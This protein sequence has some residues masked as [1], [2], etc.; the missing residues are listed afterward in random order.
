MAQRFWMTMRAGMTLV[1][2][3]TGC[4]TATPPSRMDQYVGTHP[5]PSLESLTPLSDRKGRTGLLVIADQTA[6]EAAPPLPDEAQIR[7]TEQL[8][9]RLTQSLPLSLETLT[10]TEGVR[11]NGDISPLLELAKSHD[12]E[13][14]LL[15]VASA[16]E[17]EYP[18]TVFLGWHTH[19]QPGLRRDNW[20]LLEAAL[21]DVKTRAVLLRGEGR[22]MA[23]L[24]RPMAPGI[25]QWYPVIWF[26]P[27]GPDG[28]PWW[29]PTY[30][31]APT[32]LRV[33]TMN[34]AAKRLAL[35]LQRTW[36]EFRHQEFV[37]SR[38]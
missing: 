6:E 21:I 17:Q 37:S 24:D 8:K 14:L 13:Y 27:A 10:P 32:M 3:L 20:S 16:T 35:D 18:Q 30:E 26:R 25:N 23:T 36:L 31:G 29:P 9:E 38:Q 28:R 4:A 5:A 34:D 19:S 2:V 12:M 11:P 33:V 15:V 7:F 22:S 1:V